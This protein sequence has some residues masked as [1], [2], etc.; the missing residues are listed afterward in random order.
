MGTHRQ[1]STSSSRTTPTPCGWPILP[2]GL[3]RGA[4]RTASRI[5]VVTT[6]DREMDIRRAIEAG[7]CGYVLLGGPLAEVIEGVT[8]VARGLRHLS[9][10]VAQRMADSLPRTNP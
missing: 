2:A 4:R 3:R 7:I 10:S 9:R 6:N 5:L 1:G 8:A